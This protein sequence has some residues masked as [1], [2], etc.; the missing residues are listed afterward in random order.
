M[1]SLDEVDQRVQKRLR[2]QA[3]ADADEVRRNLES[4][5]KAEE[6]QRNR[7]KVHLSRLLRQKEKANEKLLVSSIPVELVS[8][9]DRI[10]E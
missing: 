5:L 6:C 4:L 9:V 3:H 1:Q 2:R 10:V 7:R 8:Q